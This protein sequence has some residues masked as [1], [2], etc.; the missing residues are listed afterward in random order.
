V[1][2]PVVEP[3]PEVVRSAMRRQLQWVGERAGWKVAFN[4]RSV[5][6]A[7]GLDGW[8]VGAIPRAMVL[9]APRFTVT[10]GLRLKLEAEI[11][12]RLATD[13]APDA[14]VDEARDAIGGFSAAVEVVDYARPAEGLTD[15]VA[16]SFF[17]AASWFA[18]EREHF[19]PLSTDRPTVHRNDIF[20]REPTP[21]QAVPDPGTVVAR[22]AALL[23]SAGLALEA[24]D[25]I[26]C[27]SLIEPINVRPGDRFDIDY[28][29]LGTVHFEF[30]GE[31]GPDL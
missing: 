5:Q 10:T 18:A 7:L 26:L 24:G 16:H 31:Q 17:H 21:E 22:A 19:T 29:E 25:R 6:Q 28:G 14:G 8:L 23:A 9:D 15:V 4:V 1:N 11:G 27:G 3:L 13:V 30:D 20:V 2:R 12:L